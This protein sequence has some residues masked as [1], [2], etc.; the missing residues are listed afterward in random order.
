MMRQMR[1][2]VKWIMALTAVTFVGLMVF[3]WGM[4]IT[5]RSGAQATGGELGRVNGEPVTYEEFNNA[6]QNLYNQLQTQ[7]SLSAAQTRQL[8]DRAWEQVVMAKLVTQELERRGI[9]VTAS[10]IKQAARFAPPPELM[11][12]AA[13]QTNG[14]FDLNKYHQFLSSPQA[15]D[16][17]LLQ[18]ESYYRELIPRSKLFNQA[19]SASYI[20]EGELWRMWRDSRESARV[21]YIFFD[22]TTLVP[23]ARVTVSDRDVEKYYREHK[24]EFERPASAKIKFVTLDRMPNSADT[25]AARTRAQNV[26]QQLITTK[27]WKDIAKMSADS[28]SGQRAGNLGKVTRNQTV[29]P[30]EKAIFSLPLNTISDLVETQ[31]GYHIIEVTART[32]DTATVR[33]VLIPIELSEEHDTQLLELADSLEALGA[34]QGLDAAARALNLQVREGTIG[35]ARQGAPMFVPGLGMAD[36]ASV[37]I[38]DGAELGDVSDVFETPT[39]YYMV[40]L[41]EKTEKGTRPLA[42]AKPQIQAKLMEE[43]KLAEARLLARKVLDAI[44]GGSSMEQAA[45][46]NGVKVEEAGPFTRLDFVPGLGRANAAI[47]TAFGQKPNQISGVVEAQ[48]ALFIIQ[49][50]AKTEASRTEFE[51]QKAQQLQQITQAMGEQRWNL[52]LDALRKNAKIV[53]NRAT[54]LRRGASATTTA[55]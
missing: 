40:Q 13:F 12:N 48:G 31:F 41:V 8:E 23:D 22:P 24:D 32:T 47:G 34:D 20:P 6:Y 54:V 50:I 30:F 35:E 5:G 4:D 36:D 45:A 33:H 3:G 10:E 17:L 53:D 25:A 52:F 7:S 15:D 49:T 9:E 29:P 26:R 11:N 19:T 39:N 44:R 14:Q 28:G 27:N 1:D 46:A 51:A 43:K 21:R 42:E 18:L 55:Q 37:W 2:N 38:F 16:Q